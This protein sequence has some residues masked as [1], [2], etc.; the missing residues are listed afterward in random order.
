M[1]GHTIVHFNPFYVSMRTPYIPIGVIIVFLIVEYI[2]CNNIPQGNHN[3][4]E[5][6]SKIQ[7]IG[8][9]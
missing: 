7:S 6:K 2:V 3:Q 4:K 5:I 9:S 1:M 8:Y